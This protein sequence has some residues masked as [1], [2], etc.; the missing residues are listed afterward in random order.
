MKGKSIEYFF[1]L[2]MFKTIEKK[3]IKL[4]FSSNYVKLSISILK[5]LLHCLNNNFKK[6]IIFYIFF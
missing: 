1:T 5:F 3:F 6:Y 4:I 2:Y